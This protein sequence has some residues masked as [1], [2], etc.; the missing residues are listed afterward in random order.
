MKNIIVSLFAL[1]LCISCVST[2][3]FIKGD[4]TNPDLTVAEKLIGFGSTPVTMN[5]PDIY[6]DG[7]Q[8]LSRMIDLIN[9]ANDYIF[10][11]TFLGSQSDDLRPLYQAMIDASDR[12]VRIYMVIDG[13]SAYDMTDSKN[14][15]E[16]LYF[17]KDHGIKLV[18]YSP[19]SMTRLLVPWVLI[20]R[21]HRKLLVFDGKI[22]VLGGMNINYVSMG[23]DNKSKLQKDS[24]YVFESNNLSKNLIKEFITLW[25]TC[26][27][28]SIRMDEFKTYEEDDGELVGY[29]FNQ[30]P[31]TGIKVAD[32]YASLINSAESEIVLL[33]YLPLL[34]SKMY[35]S[36]Q[37]AIDR[38]VHVKMLFPLDQRGYSE[39][40]TKYIYNDLVDMGVECYYLPSSES[41][42]LHEKL[43]ITDRKYAVIGS[44]NF[45]FRSM[46]LSHEIA[47]AI[48]NE[49]FAEKLLEHVRELE[50]MA[51]YLDKELAQKWKDDDGSLL[52]YLASYWGG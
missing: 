44:S 33:P 4:S 46:G 8:W 26:S 10:I 48:D 15:L 16:P 40:G 47:M 51:I 5:E 43:M 9:G 49:D 31:S 24:M 50:L 7:K 32:V 42:L 3:T 17:L 14:Y 28:E 41:S 23:S 2:D 13:V 18:E 35:K 34:D 37:R 20:T 25:N 52:L 22:A 45:N 1:I 39:K 27:V 38:G 12:G 21:D 6:Y 19:L 11:S 30:G 29:L 36:I